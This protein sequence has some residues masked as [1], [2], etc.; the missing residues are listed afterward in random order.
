MFLFIYLFIWSVLTQEYLEHVVVVICYSSWIG[1]KE[2]RT[3]FVLQVPDCRPIQGFQTVS[4][5]TK[6]CF[7]AFCCVAAWT[8]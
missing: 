7:L 4:S 3:S 8:M 5:H 2:K 6:S 1:G